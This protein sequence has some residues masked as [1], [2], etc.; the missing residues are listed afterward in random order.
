MSPLSHSS[1]APALGS[2]KAKSIPEPNI[3]IGSL[4]KVRA[5][6][7]NEKFLSL[8]MSLYLSLS[9]SFSLLLLIKLKAFLNQIQVLTFE[10]ACEKTQ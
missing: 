3:D 10:G 7:L 5:R 2:I 8:S 4:L 6:K 1:A 9:L